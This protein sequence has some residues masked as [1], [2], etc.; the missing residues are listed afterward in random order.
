MFLAASAVIQGFVMVFSWRGEKVDHL[1]ADPKRARQLVEELPTNESKAL[2]EITYWLETINQTPGFKVD[3]RFDNVTLLDGAAR[4]HVRKLSLDY[5]SMQRQM[6]VQEHQLWT[7]IFGFWQHLGSAYLTCV[8]QYESGIVGLTLV[9]RSLPL[10]VARAM[11]AL[12]LQLKWHLLRYGRVETRIW[13]DL[14]RLYRNAE[15]LGFAN[16]PLHVYPGSHHESTVKGEFM[17]AIMLSV[18]STDGLSPLRQEIAERVVA[19]FSGAFH[20]SKRPDGCTHCFDFASPRQPVRLFKGAKSG[21]DQLF[22]GAGKALDTLEEL[23]D[24]IR[25]NREVPAE[26]NLGAS[27]HHEVVLAAL[28]HLAVCWRADLPGRSSERRLVTGRMTVVPGF[29]DAMQALDPSTSDE[30]DFSQEKAAES[31]LVV[32]VSDGGYGAVIPAL[33]SDWIR[34]G[35]LIGMQSEYSSRWMIGLIRRIANDEYNQRHVGIQTLSRTAI[36]VRIIRAGTA[37]SSSNVIGELQPAILLATA[38]DAKGEVGI[39]MREGLFST[40]DSMEM[41]IGGKPYLLQPVRLV[42]G[43]E[44]FDWGTFKVRQRK[45]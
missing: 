43:G 20:L 31:W 33:K 16:S 30:L 6:K 42:E 2:E 8:D 10:I 1:M 11:R 26:V 36:P 3:Q 29:M 4:K 44:D 45:P 34:V 7:A 21:S 39:I 27:Y 12:A 9:R 23:I 14:A 5:L 25:R 41:T 18:S 35:T 19:H 17:K 13:K 28:Q 15:K 38:P 22:F 24:R 40:R 32:N 37:N